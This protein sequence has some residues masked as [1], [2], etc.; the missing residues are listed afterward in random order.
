MAHRFSVGVLFGSETGTAGAGAIW[1]HKASLRGELR[2]I[3]RQ[4]VFRLARI[5]L[6]GGEESALGRRASPVS[7]ITY[8]KMRAC[9]AWWKNT[10]LINW[11]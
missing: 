8:I 10:L 7:G 5:C 3:C 9:F 6:F 2:G 11:L 4:I 1:L